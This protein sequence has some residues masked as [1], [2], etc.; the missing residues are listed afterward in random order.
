MQKAGPMFKVAASCALAAGAW[1]GVP[2]ASADDVPLHHV[3]YTVSSDT[4][5]FAHIYYRQ[6]DPPDWGTYSHDPYVWSPRAEAQLGPGQ[7]W[8]FDTR[9]ADPNQWAMVVAQSGT[10]A[11]ARLHTTEV[12]FHCT[13]E[14][15]GTVVATNQGPRGA[16]CSIRLW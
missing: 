5:V 15:D 11:T 6:T 13:L 9:L 7:S 16:L 8:V 1:A 10:N 4:P 2:I 3:R 14:V 12:G